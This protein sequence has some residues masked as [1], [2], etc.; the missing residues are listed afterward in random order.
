MATEATRNIG[1]SIHALESKETRFLYLVITLW[2]QHILRENIKKGENGKEK[3][4]WDEKQNDEM[5]WK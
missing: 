4:F 2:E 3:I 5:R 1:A